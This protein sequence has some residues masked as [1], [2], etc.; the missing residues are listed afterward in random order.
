[1]KPAAPKSRSD[2]AAEEAGGTLTIDLAALAANY[3]DLK[4]RAAPADC[5]AVV[6]ADA[7]GLGLRPVAQ[8]LADI[9]CTTFFVAL[10]SEAR[11]LRAA[12]PRAT[13]YVLD[14]LHPATA[15]EFHT[16]RARPVL[17]SFPEIEEWDTFAQL[18]R[19]P[20]PAAVHID[21]GMNRHGLVR[22]DA[23][24]F[25]GKLNQR[26]FAPSLIM[27]HLACADEPGHEMN[28]RQIAEVREL[29]SLFP[30]IP[31]SLANSAGVLALKD[32]HFD[33]VRPGISLYGGRALFAGDNPMRPLVRLEVRIV[34]VRTARKGDS[35]GYGAEGKLGRASRIA[36]AAAGY[37]DGIPRAAGSSAKKKG[38]E[39]IVAGQRCPLI[40]R[41][42][43]D[44]IAIDVTE[45]PED[46]VRRGDLVTLIGDGIGVDDLADSAGTIGYEILVN[47]GRRYARTYVGG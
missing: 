12:L 20:L 40:G 24:A 17:G 46:A 15:E 30:G 10:L 33:M 6:K 37:G 38:A 9:G 32:S 26:H 36:V 23:I 31:V 13:I 25:A 22:A 42:S 11:R 1:M 35:V 34:Q 45:L 27:S 4:K 29:K 5:A 14:G 47:L 8:K 44:L 43:M 16:L 21:T 18:N 19:E 39:V 41:V 3:R 28:A 7:Y 2:N